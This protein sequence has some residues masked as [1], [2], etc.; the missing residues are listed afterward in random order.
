[1]IK[2]MENLVKYWINALATYFGQILTIWQSYFSKL[3]IDIREFT[4]FFRTPKT[5]ISTVF[6]TAAIEHEETLK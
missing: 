4:L 2:N 1:M 6:K 5:F 3:F